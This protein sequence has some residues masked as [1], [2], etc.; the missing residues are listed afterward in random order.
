MEWPLILLLILGS[1]LIQLFIGMPVAFAFLSTNLIGV[2]LFMGGEIG[3]KQIVLS[4]ASSVASYSLPAVALYMLMGEAMFLTGIAPRMI[5]VLDEWIGRAPGR[6]SLEATA[7]GTVFATL[8]G[9]A[10]SGVAVL[11]SVLVPEM[12]KRHYKSSMILGPILAA[13]GLA[14]MIPPST[15]AVV[16]ATIAQVSVA[17]VLF[18]I[19][20]PGLMLASAYAVYIVVRCWRQP[21]LAPKYEPK[22]IALPRK[23]MDSV[24]Y[25]LPLALIVFLVLGTVF[26]G[27]CTPSEAAAVG[28]LGILILA[29][30]YRRLNLE[31][32]RKSFTATA[33]VT[34]MVLMIL[35]GSTAFSQILA[36]TGVAKGIVGLVTGLNASPIMIVI[37]MQIILLIMGCF[38]E[39]FSI[40]MVAIPIFFPVILALHLDPIWFAAI[41]LLNME[42]G[43]ITPPFG[44]ALFVM[45]GV[46]PQYSMTDIIG[47]SVP[48]LGLDLIIMALMVAF[49]V[50]SLLLPGMM[51]KTI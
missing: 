7:A 8:S 28:A 13:G 6:L 24:K 33:R 50:L 51:I 21:H 20:I 32:L 47:S 11:G 22:R 40:M 25:V 46:A 2:I 3:L 42:V 17:R 43:G 18:S 19:V 9:S 12:E 1:F 35:T 31:I 27:V 29:A 36:Y 34:I 15:G 16:L 41:F 44:L 37:V 30:F 14:E 23:I 49:P 26:L 48:F 39:A 5:E 45:K 38:M 4:M 10:V